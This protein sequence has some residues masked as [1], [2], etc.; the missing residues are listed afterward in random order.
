MQ[1]KMKPSEH[2]IV[3]NWKEELEMEIRGATGTCIG[4]SEFR[5]SLL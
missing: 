3:I 2:Q 4:R 5:A 1:Q